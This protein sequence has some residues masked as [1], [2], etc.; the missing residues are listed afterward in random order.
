MYVDIWATEAD[1]ILAVELKYKTRRAIFTVHGEEF[2]LQ[3][4]AA[5]DVNRYLFLKDIQRLESVVAT[6]PTATAYAILLTNVAGYWQTP[7]MRATINAAFDRVPAG[8]V[9]TG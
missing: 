4:H 5:E 7:G 8:G 9:K 3:N 2:L 1:S 6:Y